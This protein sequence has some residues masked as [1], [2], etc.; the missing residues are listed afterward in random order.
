[1]AETSPIQS[2]E[3]STIAHATEDI[4]KVENALRRLGITVPFT[5]RNLEGHHGNLIVKV[6]A[7]LSHKDAGRFAESLI[8]LLSR[9][10]RLQI[11]RDLTLHS[12]DEGNLYIRLDKQRLF[13]GEVRLSE[14][15]PVRVKIKFNRLLGE[16]KRAMTVLLESE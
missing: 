1:V 10:E 11:Q 7:R 4:S 13:L 3:I 2:V 5:R 9:T 16:S 8:K 15:D 12:D 14:E 6:D